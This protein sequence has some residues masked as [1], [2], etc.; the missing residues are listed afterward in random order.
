MEIIFELVSQQEVLIKSYGKTI[1]H[2]FTPASSGNDI[3]N[4]IQVCGFDKAYDLWGCGIFG[5]KVENKVPIKEKDL[6]YLKNEHP[7]RK[8]KF[9]K[10]LVKRGY[11]IETGHKSKQDIQLLFSDYD[12]SRDNAGWGIDNCITC[13]SRP[14][15]CEELKVVRQKDVKVEMKKNSLNKKEK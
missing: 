10:S 1:G 6:F 7:D 14:C 4:A 13:Y 11:R 9:I 8:H 3:T 5:T 12:N 2:I 15:V